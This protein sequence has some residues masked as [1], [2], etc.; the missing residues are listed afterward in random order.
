MSW[1]VVIVTMIPP[2]LLGFDAVVREAGHEPVALL[3]M[4]GWTNP[5]GVLSSAALVAAAPDDL[6][7]LMPAKR[8]DLAPLLRSME[9]D[10]VVC[11][12]F[13]WK[14]PADALAVPK[15]GWLNGH[16]S[17]LPLHRGP[18]PVAWAIRDGDDGYGISFHKM[19]AELD[20]GPILVQRPI[21]FGDFEP[22]DDFF[23][24]SGPVVGEA[25]AE[26]L[27]K[28]EA[29]EEGDVQAEGSGSYETFFDDDAVW[30]DLARPAAEVHRL[31]WAWRYGMRVDGGLKGAVLEMDG[32]PVRV[33]ATALT[34]V[35]GAKRVECGDAPLWIVETEE[36]SEA[37]LS[38]EGAT[39][40]SAPAPS[41]P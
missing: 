6:N 10:L 13:P 25:L 18:T 8:S 14:I 36:L 41:T 29:G 22:P 33:L 34:E 4:R 32:T 37:E 7:I 40:S 1:R 17:L 20:T 26:A 9:P 19:D 11:M 21:P 35:D 5:E 3:T 23:P 30:L 15:H 31:A 28:L 2:V 24:K 16:P 12:A 39:Q 38:G 27:A